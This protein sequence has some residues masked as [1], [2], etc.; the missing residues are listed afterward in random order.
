MWSDG[1]ATTVF[2]KQDVSALPERLR[3]LI[4]G[5]PTIV[6][7]CWSAVSRSKRVTSVAHCAC[8]GDVHMRAAGRVWPWI[9][10]GHA[11]RGVDYHHHV[12]PVCMIDQMDNAGDDAIVGWAYDGFP[13][14]CGNNPDSSPPCL[15]PDRLRRT[16]SKSTRS[17]CSTIP[18]TATASTFPA[19]RA[20]RQTPTMGFRA[21]P[22]TAHRVRSS[23]IRL[24]IARSSW[25]GFSTCRNSSLNAGF[26][27]RS[28]R[29]VGACGLRGVRGA[30][31][32]HVWRGCD[33]ARIHP[34]DVPDPWR[35]HAL[36]PQRHQPDQGADP[37]GVRAVSF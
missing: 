26:I 8:K 2:L 20:R 6:A 10:G 27:D 24:S 13:I 4:L 14:Y 1:V 34:R 12:K 16:T 3:G 22:A 30:E 32:L 11:G 28:G 31:F 5:V 37:G 33:H 36:W 17:V 9:C 23:S 25:T 15:L 35:G 21:A 19:A 7:V 29:G 18:G